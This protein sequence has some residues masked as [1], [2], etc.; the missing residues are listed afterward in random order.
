MAGQDNAG[1]EGG[2]V[3]PNR[4]AVFTSTNPSMMKSQIIR[5]RIFYFKI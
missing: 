4:F 2:E 3:W 5:A 1:N